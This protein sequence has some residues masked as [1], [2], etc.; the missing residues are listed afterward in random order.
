MARILITQSLVPGGIDPLMASGHELTVRDQP[1]PMPRSELLAAIGETDALLCLLSDTIDGEI[2]SKAPRLK[3]IA[4]VAVGYDN[5][6]VDAASS[7]GILVL[8]TPGVLDAST[9]DLALFLMLAARRRTTEAEHVL[10]AGRWQGWGLNQ[11]LG[12]DLSGATVGL[13]GFGRIAQAVARRLAGFECTVLHHT[14]HDT[15]QPGWCEDLK[16]MSRV[17]DVLSIHVPRSGSTS[18]LVDAEILAS[19]PRS[20]VVI[21]TARGSVLDESALADAL[22]DGQIAGAGLDVYD[23]EPQVNRKLLDAPNVTLLPH[24]GSAT[25]AT[26]LAMCRVAASGLLEV[27]DGGMPSNVVQW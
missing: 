16:E 1:S 17:V 8:N 15:L 22:H 13:V 10:R 4:N 21:N 19:L 6:D 25:L 14:R 27:L 3:V 18:H 7:R 5:I 11:Q 2:L 26:R 24:I 23:G 12:S 20:A 9:A